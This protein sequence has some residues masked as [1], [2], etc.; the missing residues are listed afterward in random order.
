MAGCVG[1]DLAE[2]SCDDENK[3][4]SGENEEDTAVPASAVTAL[5]TLRAHGKIRPGQKVLINV[6]G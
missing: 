2:L 1:A 3:A 6:T 5:H 4:Q